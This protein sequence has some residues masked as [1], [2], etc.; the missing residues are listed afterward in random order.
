MATDYASLMLSSKKVEPQQ[1]TDYASSLVGGGQKNQSP[2]QKQEGGYL[3]ETVKNIPSSAGRL[4]QS[5]VEPLMSPIETGK[6]LY[7]LA[8]SAADLLI[9]GE[10]GNEDA[11]R[12]VGRYFKER[13]GGVEN[14]SENF[15]SDPVGMLA[16]F[17]MFMTGAG[18]VAKGGAKTA[19]LAG[20]AKTSNALTTA[21]NVASKAGA[22]TDPLTN[23]AVAAGKG[24]DLTQK[25]VKTIRPEQVYMS[26]MKRGLSRAVTPEQQLANAQTGV[27]EGVSNLD[28]L[29]TK[30]DDYDTRIGATV[31]NAAKQGDMIPKALM[32]EELEKMKLP[33]SPYFEHADRNMYMRHIDKQIE[34]INDLYPDVEIPVD[35][36]Q[37]FK[38]NMQKTANWNK[39]GANDRTLFKRELEKNASRGAKNALA[40]KYP[41]LAALNKNDAA[42]HE[43]EKA[44]ELAV[45]QENPLN[46]VSLDMVTK[47]GLGG[48]LGAATGT[49]AGTAAGSIIGL[50]IAIIDKP[51]VKRKLGVALEKAR[52]AGYNKG[53]LNKAKDAVRLGG[54]ASDDESQ[55]KP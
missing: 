50:G 2:P 37:K 1:G 7:N 48:G 24:Y 27:R 8:G 46:L 54:I 22:V 38:T 43:L 52:K 47:V 5:I 30:M 3:E 36:V 26:G 9:P 15:K 34:K 10:H 40:E 51:I 20:M 32:V 31:E 23:V 18:A 53:K 21:G 16:D 41:E 29:A 49:A 25:V 35:V 13:F 11:A 44:L 55:L 45:R 42:L 39:M 17:A 14:I 4:A 6:N 12:N 33:D 19:E 28:Q